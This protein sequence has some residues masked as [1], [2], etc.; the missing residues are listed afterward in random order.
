M[1]AVAGNPYLPETVPGPGDFECMFNCRHEIWYR[2][3]LIKES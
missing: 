1:G 2:K 3:V